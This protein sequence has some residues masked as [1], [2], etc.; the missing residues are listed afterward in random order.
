MNRHYRM[1]PDPLPLA[2]H[3]EELYARLHR[4]I[5]HYHAVHPE[6][7]STVWLTALSW[8]LADAQTVQDDA[9]PARRPRTIAL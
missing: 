5:A 4:Q 1:T 8:L 3:S 2:Y 9:V 7:P 6:L